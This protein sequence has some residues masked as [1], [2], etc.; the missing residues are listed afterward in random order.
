MIEKAFKFILLRNT[1]GYQEKDYEVI[2]YQLYKN[3]EIANYVLRGPAPSWPLKKGEYA[4]CLGA[5]QTFGRFV[6]KPFSMLLEESLSI[7]VVNL[8]AP[9]AGPK[10]FNRKKN[11]ID[12][13]N[14]AKFV[15]VQIMPGRSVGNSLYETKVG[16]EVL[17][18]KADSQQIAASMAWKEIIENHDTETIQRLVRETRNNWYNA[19]KYLLES[20][21][22]PKIA[23]WISHRPPKYQETYKNVA[24]LFGGGSPQLINQ[25]LIDK[26]LPLVD[27][28]VESVGNEGLPQKLYSRFTGEEVTIKGRKDL[29][30]KTL[31]YNYYYASPEMHVNAFHKLLPACAKVLENN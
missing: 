19:M 23:L 10:F 27:E 1:M 4:V 29:G 20:I 17:L 16:G 30:S 14:N 28:Y 18:R 31:Q 11:L 2:D 5:A 25:R 9:G 7:P 22:V 15:I 21:H 3:E 13:I 8:G 6:E 26:I 24:G 12:F